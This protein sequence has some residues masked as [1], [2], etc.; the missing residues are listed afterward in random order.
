MKQRDE[1]NIF[2][3]ALL[4]FAFLLFLFSFTGKSI[5]KSAEDPSRLTQNSCALKIPVA[6]QPSDQCLHRL[7][8]AFYPLPFADQ[9]SCGRL[10]FLVQTKKI[11]NAD[12]HFISRTQLLMPGEQTR[13]YYHICSLRSPE[14][15]A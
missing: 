12:K 4:L 1:K 15:Q 6:E 14:F 3:D 11:R 9:L 7:T 8:R 2:S 13:F 5:G 10:E